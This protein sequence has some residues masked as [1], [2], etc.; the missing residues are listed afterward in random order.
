[1]LAAI[2]GAIGVVAAAI[3]TYVLTYLLNR[4]QSLWQKRLERSNA[5]LKQLYGPLLSLAESSE[6]SWKMFGEKY[7]EGRE[8]MIREEGGDVWISWVTDVSNRLIT[9]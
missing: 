8:K 3:V 5:Q 9:R 1:M 6:R 2:I 7:G 4:G